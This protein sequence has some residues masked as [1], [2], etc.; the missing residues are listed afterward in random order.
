MQI[1]YWAVV[2]S[3]VVNMILGFAWYAQSV[4]G[5][6][7][8]KGLGKSKEEQKEEMK[9]RNMVGIFFAQFVSAL[10]TAYAL[11]Y[12]LNLA[13]AST[14]WDGASMGLLV[15]VGFVLAINLGN[16]LFE[17]RSFSLF[18]I[19]S[20]YTVVSLVLT[21]ALLAVWR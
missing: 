21:G 19:N 9:S 12:I 14:M 1:N 16:Y 2:A 7:W 6:L 3:A 13:G 4:F 18:Y 5:R 10:V 11:A 15:G 17:N 20:S 8:L